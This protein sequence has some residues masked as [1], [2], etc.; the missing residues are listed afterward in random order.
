[1]LCGGVRFSGVEG[2][3]SALSRGKLW[4]IM[5][6][7]FALV[8][9]CT[10][11]HIGALGGAVE[12]SYSAGTWSQAG[13]DFRQGERENVVLLRDGGLSLVRQDGIGYGREGTYT[14]PVWRAPASFNAVASRWDL[15]VPPETSVTLEIRTSEDGRNWTSWREIVPDP[16][17]REEGSYGRMVTG[18]SARHLQYRVRLETRDPEVTP[19]LNEVALT[20]I[21]THRGP[22]LVVA[23]G[24]VLKLA[25]EGGVPPPKIIS[26]RGW[27]CDE[28]W[29][30]WEPEYRPVQTF[31]IH[32][33]V[34]DNGDPDQVATIRAIYYYHAV[35]R[36]WGDIGYNYLIDAQGNIYE[37]RKGG[38][39]VV[40][41]HAREYNY[42][43]VGIA[44]LG[45]YRARKVTQEMERALAQ[46]IAWEADQCSI[47]PRGQ[48]HFIDRM[49]P[50]IMGHRDVNIT[51]CPGDQA[52]NKLPLIRQGVW[53][54]MLQVDPKVTLSF[55]REGS[56]LG[57][58]V[59]VLISSSS[60]TVDEVEF[61]VDGVLAFSGPNPLNWSWDTA[62]GP[63][64][65]RVLKAVALS[66]SGRRTEQVVRV[67]VDNTPPS[68]SITI[69]D[70]SRYVRHPLVTLKLKAEDNISGV[71][72]MQ[73]WDGRVPFG[74]LEPYAS[75]K[76]WVL[77]Y[78]DGLKEV[79]VRFLDEM[80]RVSY[81]YT[82]TV[83]LDMMSPGGWVME[84]NEAG[85]KVSVSDATSG[86][87]PNTVAYR[88]SSSDGDYWGNWVDVSQ[89]VKLK[90]RVCTVILQE[91]LEGSV[92]QFRAD[93]RAGNQ[94]LSPVWSVAGHEVVTPTPT[95]EGALP[96]NPLPDLAV[97]NMTAE[98][99]APREGS[100]IAVTLT[101][102]NQGMADAEG[103]WVELYADPVEEPT[104]NSLCTEL[105]RGAFW[106]VSGL[107]A[108][109]AVTLTT[110]NVYEL[111]SDYPTAWEAGT[112]HFYAVVDAYGPIKEAG[113]IRESDEGNNLL[114]PLVLEVARG[115]SW[116]LLNQLIELISGWLAT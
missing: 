27:G 104:L 38:D 115:S 4:G 88:V 73:L 37:G 34:T 22:D 42:G 57:G 44:L 93:D 31:I 54:R 40:G 62:R 63:D 28:S 32:H 95:P 78:G 26:R 89:A 74:E 102:V 69:G 114:G 87:D 9:S 2:I 65:E 100:P 109:E 105:G 67:K 46:L 111:Y 21:D 19:V 49:L 52:Y 1:V 91:A 79:G 47:D 50:N 68:G 71:A 98:P 45:D 108:G 106:Y 16:D 55:P 11:P 15:D 64:G 76:D 3:L 82:A 58:K 92:M 61:Y 110:E 59:E 72:R 84:D 60:P 7:A 86:L 101:V 77:P 17:E 12:P 18:L 107:T 80:G 90:G 94:G 75:V 81:I 36:G 14:S 29:A 51:S 35:T 20:H 99:P 53:E 112:H 23:K 48:R 66:V 5:A 8:T 43:S 113:L 56:L 10:G 39:G 103:F 85:V 70:G 41:G 33:T 6:L 13:T 83:T 25:Q 96:P 116:D 24:M 97:W 30:S